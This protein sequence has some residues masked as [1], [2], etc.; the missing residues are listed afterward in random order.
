MQSREKRSA[1]LVFASNIEKLREPKPLFAISQTIRKNFR[2]SSARI[3]GDAGALIPGLVIGDTANET[4]VFAGE[5]KRVGLTHLTAVSGENFA[6]VASFIGWFLSRI[7]PKLKVRLVITAI[8]LVLFVFL[9][10][11]SPSVIRAGAMAAIS[12]L[13]LGKGIRVPPLASIGAA[14]G[15]ILLIDP[16][17]SIDPGF[18]LSAGA[19]AGIILLAPKLKLPQTIAIPVAATIFCTPVIIALSGTL[20]LVSIPANLL[21]SP[22]V[23]QIGR[24]HV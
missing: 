12:L 24:A 22:L 11:P 15:L 1:A 20:S 17:Q 6:I 10:R 7:I 16:W 2:E 18:A 5:M 9:V 4:L 8:F 14:V 13:S 21:V 19:T 23:A 3:G